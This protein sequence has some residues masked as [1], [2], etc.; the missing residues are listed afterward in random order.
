MKEERAI[1]KAE[2][3]LNNLEEQREALFSRAKLLSKQREAIAFAALTGDKQ[4]KAR[5]AEINAE[6]TSHSANI[7]S[8]EA[9][10]T[11]ARANLDAAQRNEAIAADRAAAE[12]ARKL[13]DEFKEYGA[14]ADEALSDAISA[15]LKMIALR[16]QMAALGITAPSG[17]QLRINSV[18]AVKS[19]LQNL[20]QPWINDFEFA[21]LAPSQKKSFKTISQGWGEMIERQIAQRVGE[22][23]T[24]AA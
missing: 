13:N 8:V 23:K 24:E 9:A 7:A 3:D 6:D 20:P 10:L 5:L 16:D 21:R 14:D 1:E 12:Q 22:K 17:Q 19:A 4:A 2:R 18:V 11:V 15:I